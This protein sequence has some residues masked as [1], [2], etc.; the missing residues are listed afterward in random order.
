MSDDELEAAIAFVNEHGAASSQAVVGALLAERDR[1]AEQVNAFQRQEQAIRDFLGLKCKT[2]EECVGCGCQMIETSCAVFDLTQERDRLAA[3][4]AELRAACE[5]SLNHW[6]NTGG[7]IGEVS[8]EAFA[9]LRAALA[10]LE[11]R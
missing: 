5:R 1:L 11:T 2:R 10:N 3:E 9:I 7:H 6:D 8:C 4:L